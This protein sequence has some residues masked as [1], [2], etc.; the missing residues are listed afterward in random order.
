M[1]TDGTIVAVSRDGAHRFSKTPV[2][3]IELVEG[4]GV[5]GDAH[6]GATVQHRSR[7]RRD[8][9]QPNLRQVH[10]IHGEL[11]D[12]VAAAGFAVEPGELGEN[13]TTR[14]IALLDLPRDTEL[15]VGTARVRVTGLRNPCLQIDAFSD[16]LLREIVGRDASGN[17]VRKGGVMAVVIASGVVRAG[18]PVRVVSTP[19]QSLPLEPV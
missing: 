1:T 13:I 7:V 2:E 9:T 8:P 4:L 11:L 3:S 16:G 18:D 17:V 19:A 5:R 12:D 15:A 10:L 6:F 14:G